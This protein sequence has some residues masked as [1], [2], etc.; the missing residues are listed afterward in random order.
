VASVDGRNDIELAVQYLHKQFPNSK[1][2]G[3]GFSLGGAALLKVACKMIISVVSTKFPSF[4][5]CQIYLN[6]I[7]SN[8]CK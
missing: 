1:L 8:I 4:L 3:L 7:Q 5:K 6:L 2:F